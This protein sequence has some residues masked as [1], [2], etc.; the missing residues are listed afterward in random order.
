MPELDNQQYLLTK[1]YQNSSNLNAR[2]Q[3]HARFSTNKYGWH[4]WIFDQLKIVAGSHM[5]ELGCGPASLWSANRDRIPADWHITLSDFSEGMIENARQNLSSIQHPFSFA[6]IDAQTIP[7]ADASLDVVIAN[8]ML[9]HVPDRPKALAEI[10]RVLKPEGR[11]Y[12]STVGNQ[13]LQ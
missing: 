6:V 1:Q 10:Q 8:H 12:A 5:L 11:L 3:L 7:F 13:H 4:R 2:I 9:Y